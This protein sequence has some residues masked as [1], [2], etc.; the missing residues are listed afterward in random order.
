[1]DMREGSLLFHQ[2]AHE[3]QNGQVACALHGGSN[4]ALEFQ[5]VAR[6]AA[7]QQLALFV[8]KLEQKV[9]V[10]VVNVFNAEFAETAVF[11]GAQPDF[12]V[13]QE[14]DIFS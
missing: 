12:G 10:F 13:A 5:A 14:F 11:F 2:V 8:D 6:D 3:G 7:G 4:A 9:G 1:M